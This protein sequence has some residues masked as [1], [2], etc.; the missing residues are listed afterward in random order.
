MARVPRTILVVLVVGVGVDGC[1]AFGR[2]LVDSGRLAAS[3]VTAANTG[4]A[5][6]LLR[7]FWEAGE[8]LP[9][10]WSTE[11]EPYPRSSVTPSA[12]KA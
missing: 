5:I 4:E 10:R 6:R 7:R 3:V 2:R 9:L 11:S 1:P 12:R 8:P